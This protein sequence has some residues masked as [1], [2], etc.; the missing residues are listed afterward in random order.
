MGTWV[1]MTKR[2]SQK[3]NPSEIE[4]DKVNVSSLYLKGRFQAEIAVE[5]G[6]SQSTVSR[7]I[8]ELVN[9]WQTER[10]YNINEAKARELA[11]IDQVELEAWKA[12]SRSQEDAV[13]E[14]EGSNH[15][16]AFSQTSTEG[17]AGDPRFLSMVIDCI[18]QRCAI[19]GVEAPKKSESILANLDIDKLSDEQLK[20]IQDGEDVLNVILTTAGQRST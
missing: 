5:L 9:E 2:K 20:R 1:H 6:I 4:R 8:K 10:V 18:K 15:Q 19:L 14:V 16:G 17:Q 3:R 11:K 12:W 7:I 13:K